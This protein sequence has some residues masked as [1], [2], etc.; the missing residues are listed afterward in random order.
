MK[1]LLQKVGIPQSPQRRTLLSGSCS[2]PAGGG[3][4]GDGVG[5]D[6][7]DRHQRSHHQMD[8]HLKV[9]IIK[10]L[11]TLSSSASFQHCAC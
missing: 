10:H 6:A 5:G 2:C 4:G 1:I 9:K 7:A 11:L 3:G 8:L